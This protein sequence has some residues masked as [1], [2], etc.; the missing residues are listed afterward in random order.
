MKAACII[1]LV[2]LILLNIVVKAQSVFYSNTTTTNF[3]TLSGWSS[4]TNGTGTNPATLNNS[5]QLVVQSGHTKITSTDA[6]VNRLTVQ[7]NAT[8]TA[9]HS[10]NISGTN[11]RFILQNN[12]TYIHN[13]SANVSNTIF[14][15]VEEFAV[16][17]TFRIQNW[18]SSGTPLTPAAL[19]RSVT[20]GVDG[21]NYFYGNLIIDWATSG[22]WNQNWP[23]FPLG[24]YLTAG[25]F[26][27]LSVGNLR[28]TQNNNAQPDV[29]VAGD[30]IMNSSGSGNNT[31]NFSSGN[32]CV[33][34]LNV[35][36][37]VVHQAGTITASSTSSFGYIWSYG[38]APSFW[39]FSGGN[40]V[41]VAYLVEGN[42]TITL[43]SNLSLG[44]GMIGAQM[45]INNPAT[46]DLQQF[47]IS[48]VTNGAFISATGIIRTAHAS[49]LWT[50]GQ[51]NRS[52]SN[53][54]NFHI[55]LLEGST[56]EY[57]G[58]S[59]QIISSLAS[60]V[61][62]FDQYQNVR[63][64]GGVTRVLENNTTFNGNIN[65]SGAGNSILVN[66]HN[67]TLTGSASLSNH[68][69][70]SYFQLVPQTAVNGRLR[71]NG[72]PAST[73]LFPIGTPTRYLPVSITPVAA[74][75]DFSVSVF[76]GTT[77]NGL[78]GGPNFNA[79]SR[80]LQVNSVWRVDRVAG[81][82]NA[83]LRFD[84]FNDTPQEGSNFT[85]LPNSQ[86]GIWRNPGSGWILIPPPTANAN[87]NTLN[88]AS[89]T[90]TAISN[91][92]TAGT[93]M[94][95][96][97]SNLNV[98]TGVL[99]SFELQ[100][101]QQIR[102]KWEVE[103][104]ASFA[105]FEL[106]RSSDG[107]N[108]KNI[109]QI[110]ATAQTQYTHNDVPPAAGRWFYRLRMI[111]LTGVSS[112][113]NVL[114]AQWKLQTAGLKITGNPVGNELRFTHMAAAENAT[115]R[116]IGL[117]GAVALQGIIPAASSQQRVMVAQL[118]SGVYLLQLQYANGNS[119]TARFI[120]Q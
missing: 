86:I 54:N 28:F 7:A 63:L 17:S 78:P 22:N 42:K 96:I 66:Q 20:S 100:Q 25:D 70:A 98:L 10:I 113:S 19:S 23:S 47:T 77:T 58:A 59:G 34:Y 74:G 71:M 12:S 118:P 44:T 72:L 65:F 56:V 89:T 116:I 43:Q 103:E 40:R 64:T 117:N 15:G 31:L 95:Y 104:P 85:T 76:E 41:R 14:N 50:S 119:E 106:Q 88:F 18:Q 27:I 4:N 68:G 84:W 45:Q 80:R 46:L 1:H 62:P 53:A 21:I 79:T 9:N 82:A 39:N 29:Y 107:L 30:F 61:S 108:F 93:G 90:A 6:V 32:G 2:V 57:T 109:A 36:G 55:R 101:Q 33:A 8:V 67:V 105:S 24:T 111:D 11:A 81:T 3:N 83:H 48:D 52:V 91:F 5:V 16:N 75:S 51:T 87:N 94:P 102:L 115:Y 97:V 110:Q 49:G 13:N 112:Y 99:R 37:N 35:N 114:N 120:R 38:T 26:R 69:P 73:R 92:G 60:N